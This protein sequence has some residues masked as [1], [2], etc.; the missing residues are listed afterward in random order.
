M[1]IL[2]CCLSCFYV[3]KYSYQ[4]N[5]LPKVNL[6]HGH[7][8]EIIA[9]TETFTAG[10]TLGYVNP[11]QYQT[12][13][14]IKI[15]RVPYAKWLP[16]FLMKKI[17][18]YKGVYALI[19]K[20]EPDIIMFHGMAAFELLN[21]VKYVKKHS[22]VKLYVDAHEDYTNSGRNFISKYILHKMIY[23]S[24]IK[25]SSSH[26]DQILYISQETKEF[27][28]DAYKAP[29]NKMELFP[30]GGEVVPKEEKLRLRRAVRDG[31]KISEDTLLIMH[32]GKLD[33][34]K[35]TDS[36]IEAVNQIPSEKILLLIAGSLPQANEQ[37]WEMIQNNSKV[38]W[39]GWLN[40]EELRKYL[41]ACDVYAQP[42]SQ[43]ITANNATC[44]GAPVLLYPQKSYL[45]LFQDNVLWVKDTEDIYNALYKL[46]QEPMLKNRLSDASYR[47]ANKMFDY[48]SLALRIE[49]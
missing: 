23:R 19:E 35:K 41:C 49:K 27:L 10:G 7:I 32:S 24:I 38:K 48:E 40:A 25:K 37:L 44:C 20:F 4:E 30:L 13:E 3:D 17:R 36:L 31:L 34:L 5:I 33:T 39:L 18:S 8:V 11:A 15:T 45:A 1:R 6:D 2:H 9:S 26:I 21:V 28:V 14:G 29:E 16:H 46:I 12:A 47:L 42:G 43:S 22:N